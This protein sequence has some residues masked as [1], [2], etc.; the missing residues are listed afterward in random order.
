MLCV[1]SK[2]TK[3]QEKG[4]LLPDPLDFALPYGSNKSLQVGKEVTTKNDI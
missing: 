4:R 1:Q 2:W 3:S